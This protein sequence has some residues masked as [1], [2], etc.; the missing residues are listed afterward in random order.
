MPLNNY[1]YVKSDNLI[2]VKNET[3]FI[4]IVTDSDIQK[5]VLTLNLHL[6]NPLYLIM[7]APVI[8]HTGKYFCR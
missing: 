2:V 3:D 4:G 6:D 1:R 7:S 8:M 5:R